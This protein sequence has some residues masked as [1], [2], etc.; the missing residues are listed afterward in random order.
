MNKHIFLLWLQGWNKAPWLQKQVLKSWKINNPTWDI[1]LI[2][3]N[4]LNNYLSDIDYL[5]D[6]SKEI[7][8]QA[9][10]DIIRL[11]LLRKYGGVWADSTLLCM[12]PLENWAFEA[13]QNSGLW[14]YHGHGAGLKSD[15]GPASWFIISEKEGYLITKWKEACDD[16]WKK[17]NKAKEYFWMDNLF[18]N[19]LISDNIFKSKWQATPFLYC[20][21]IGSSH[22]FANYNYKM[23][24][25]NSEIKEILRAKPPYVLKF[26]SNWNKIFKKLRKKEIYNSNAFYAI[27]MSKRKF[28]YVH[29]FEKAFS[30]ASPIKTSL[31][32]TKLKA[33]V[34]FNLELFSILFKRLK[35]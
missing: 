18:K 27:K 12:Q 34:K 30:L 9:K 20:E 25:N 10:S 1:Q 17:N 33:F 16:F 5:N 14:M 2:D 8:F 3:S 11:S 7:T 26:S 29:N 24:K 15:L 35:K 31:F 23:D 32:L 6:K 22:T 28:V 4:N 13:V 21:K 19:L